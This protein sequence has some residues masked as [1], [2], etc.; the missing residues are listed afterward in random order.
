MASITEKINE[1]ETPNGEF[2]QHRK[3]LI[4]METAIEETIRPMKTYLLMSYALRHQIH[5]TKDKENYTG[6]LQPSKNQQYSAEYTHQ[7][8]ML[9]DGHYL[10]CFYIHYDL[11][12][13]TVY[14][15]SGSVATQEIST[16]NI[17]D[18]LK[19][20]IGIDT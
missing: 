14:V 6:I 10:A 7:F 16:E 2:E 13:D 15:T 3:K 8:I 9:R 1:L 5:A 18:V 12:N 19:T 11:K 4:K 17:I 20:T